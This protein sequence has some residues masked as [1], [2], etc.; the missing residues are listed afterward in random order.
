MNMPA[1]IDAALLTKS[2]G[3]LKLK[4]NGHR[5]TVYGGPYH[6]K[7]DHVMGVRLEIRTPADED[8]IASVDI[9]D[10]SVPRSLPEFNGALLTAITELQS[11]DPVW[12]GCMG[13]FGRTGMFMSALLQIEELQAIRSRWTSK[14]PFIYR[15]RV[16]GIAARALH[17]VRSEYCDRAVETKEQ[18]RWMEEVF[19]PLPIVKLL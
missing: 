9:P 7:P 15:R 16:K 13:G 3:F 1:R 14:I 17:R 12:V 6:S 4:F 10:F 18:E 2:V 11:G 8:T 19:N 5:V